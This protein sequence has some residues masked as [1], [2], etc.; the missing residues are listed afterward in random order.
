MVIAMAH[1]VACRSSEGDEL[2]YKNCNMKLRNMGMVLI[3]CMSIVTCGEKEEPTPA[4]TSGSG[5]PTTAN[6]GCSNKAKAVCDS[7]C[8]KWVVGDGCRCR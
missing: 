6:C 1:L 3:V 5:C 7:S 8:C 2:K 4:P